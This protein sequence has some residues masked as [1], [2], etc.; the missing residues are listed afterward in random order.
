MGIQG[1]SGIDDV[2]SDIMR[3]GP[4]ITQLK[5]QGLTN[6]QVLNT[7]LAQFAVWNFFNKLTLLDIDSGSAKLFALFILIIARI[8]D[9]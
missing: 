8:I 7:I 3:N 9:F 5:Q 1:I 6:D 2:I 4:K